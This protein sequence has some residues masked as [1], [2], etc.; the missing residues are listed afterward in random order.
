MFDEHTTNATFD[1]SFEYEYIDI[2]VP[3]ARLKYKDE[4]K[5]VRGVPFYEVTIDGK[6]VFRGNAPPK[7]IFERMVNIQE[8][9]TR[10][11]ADNTDGEV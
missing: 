2:N 11:K 3:G 7:D 9:I 10:I 6:V 1:N 5:G 4:L 8:Y